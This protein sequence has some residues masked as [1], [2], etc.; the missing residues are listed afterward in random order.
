MSPFFFYCFILCSKFIEY[1]FVMF[2]LLLDG[3]YI[4]SEYTM[5][6]AWSSNTQIEVM[7]FS[8]FL[9]LQ[10]LIQVNRG[11][12]GRGGGGRKFLGKSAIFINIQI[13]WFCIIS[14]VFKN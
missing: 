11:G 6:L 3:I 14:L 9:A 12:A 8:A 13:I 5:D 4:F 10:V 1:L 7:W 2:V